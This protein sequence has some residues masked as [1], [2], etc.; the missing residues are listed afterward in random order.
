M[1]PILP[2]LAV[3][4]LAAPVA[5]DNSLTEQEKKDG[6]VLLFDGRTLDGWMTSN[7]KPSKRPVEDGSLN[8]HKCGGYMLV[9]EKQWGDFTLSLDF[10]LSKG[11]NSGVFVR[12][13]S[14]TP[15]PGRDV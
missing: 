4:A 14:L 5:A 2:L 13:A 12:T 10:K 6:W 8:P 11:C 3:A 1:R 15:R 7:S 9:H